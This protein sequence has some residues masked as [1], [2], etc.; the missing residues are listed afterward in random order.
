M[1]TMSLDGNVQG[2]SSNSP[3]SV[4]GWGK[5]AGGCSGLRRPESSWRGGLPGL[6]ASRAPREGSP[7]LGGWQESS[8]G[9]AAD[10]DARVLGRQGEGPEAAGL[11]ASGSCEWRGELSS[12]EER[13]GDS[14]AEPEA[15]TGRPG[16]VEPGLEGTQ[17]LETCKR[18]VQSHHSPLRWVG[19]PCQPRRDLRL[20]AASHA[21][22]PQRK[23]GRRGAATQDGR[24]RFRGDFECLKLLRVHRPL[25]LALSPQNARRLIRT[26]SLTPL[27]V[28]QTLP[29]TPPH[30]PRA[31]L[32]IF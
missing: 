27:Q 15:S 8:S 21:H 30:P 3:P 1:A 12:G 6:E 14:G 20:A 10:G 28:V 32:R 5:A 22:T 11:W 18:K 25:L 19:A 2:R 9:G 7:R 29:R 31:H 23:P 26:V 4:R 16:L 13:R 24:K 17:A